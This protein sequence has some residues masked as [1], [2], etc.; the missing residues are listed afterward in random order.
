[1]SSLYHYFTQIYD[2][3]SPSIPFVR[4]SLL[5]VL[6]LLPKLGSFLPKANGVNGENEPH[7]GVGI[8]RSDFPSDFLFGSATSAA[9]TE[10]A[11]QADGR[12]PS[13]WDYFVKTNTDKIADN[14]SNDVAIDSYRRYKEDIRH[15]KDVGLNSYRFSIS[16]TRIVPTGSVSDGINHKGIDHYNRLIDEI[17]QNGLTPFVTL[18]HFDS[19]EISQERYGGFL[20]VSIV[21]DF[22]DYV[23]ICFK[24]FGDRVKHWI[25][26]NEPL[27]IA[28][29]G[30]ETGQTPPGRCSQPLGS[31]P[32]GNSSTEPY[33]A[34]HNL[35]LAHT[36][37]T[38]LY[39]QKFQ[40]V[41]GGEIGITLVGQYYE[42]YSNSPKD[43]EAAK[44]AIDFNFGWYMD[45]LVFGDYPYTM[46]KLVKDRLPQFTKEQQ[47]LIRGSFDFIGINYYTSRYAQAAVS[48]NNNS[49]KSFSTDSLTNITTTRADGRQIGLK[50]SGSSYIYI[51]PEGLQKILE[52]TKNKYSSPKIYITEN[53]VTEARNDTLKLQTALN[54]RHRI[55]FIT[56]HLDRVH[57]AMKNG[58]NVGGYFYWSI[59]DSFEFSDGYTVRYGLYFVDYKNNLRRVPKKSATWYR[60]FL[61][62]N[63]HV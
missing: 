5:N 16:W 32:A 52:Y 46:R 13:V 40:A 11:I 26:I 12:G 6:D 23:E 60:N 28:Q 24:S 49:T 50:A 22:R 56:E 2:L 51:Y 34:S 19:P 20:N 47:D 17:V 59:F 55:R 54:D 10:G 7:L 4:N 36:A 30:Y 42:P 48:D 25:T 21:G 58:V 31:C 15:L 1:M 53:G 38:N 37:A 35:L 9:Q 57:K 18:F 33:I 29:Y 43:I 63:S 39:K 27:I 62:D 8:K 45:P 44:R 14:S 3:G 41:Q 61:L